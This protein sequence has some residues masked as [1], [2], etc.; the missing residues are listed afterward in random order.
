MKNNIILFAAAKHAIIPFDVTNKDKEMKVL[1]INLKKYCK[2]VFTGF[3][4][5]K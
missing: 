3:Y 4:H 5:C 1:A 2:I